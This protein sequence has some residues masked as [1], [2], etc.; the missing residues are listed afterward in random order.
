LFFDGV[1]VDLADGSTHPVTRGADATEVYP[2]MAETLFAD[3][4]HVGLRGEGKRRTLSESDVYGSGRL[5]PDRSTL[6]DTSMWPTPAVAY[7][8]RTGRQRTI[9][10]PWSSFSLIGFS[11]EDRFLGVAQ[12]IDEDAPD[13]VLRAQQVVSCTLPELTCTPA[14]PV[15]A[16]EDAE[17]GAYFQVEAIGPSPY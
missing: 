14:S 2:G 13:N 11:G 3:G 4:Y 15:I 16:T 12:K 6:F 10:A 1:T 5:S 9:D 17:T 7:D 8:A